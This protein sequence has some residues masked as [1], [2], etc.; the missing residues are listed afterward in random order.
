MRRSRAESNKCNNCANERLPGRAFC[1][2]CRDRY[3]A[4]QTAR[5]EALKAKGLCTVCGQRPHVS[6]RTLCRQCLE[7]RRDKK[8]DET[9]HRKTKGLCVT[10]G[11][12]PHLP[13]CSRCET[14]FFKALSNQHVGNVCHAAALRDLFTAQNGRCAYS[15]VTLTLGVNAEL[16]H[17]QPISQGG[18]HDLSN[19]QFVHSVV[20]QMKWSY[21]EQDFLSFVKAIYEH[22]LTASERSP[23]GIR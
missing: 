14:C 3:R 20:N 22:R 11:R 19:A 8:R 23:H 6:N 10:C 4:K 13:D 7:Y 5:A 18:S 21:T 2:D 17:I 1:A 16:D 12:T 15:G 9:K